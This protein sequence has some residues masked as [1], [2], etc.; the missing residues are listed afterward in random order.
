[1][2]SL[3]TVL[4]DFDIKPF[5]HILPSLEKASIATADLLTLDAV[6]VAR[7]A[8]VPPGEVKKLAT[9]LINGLHGCLDGESSGPGSEQSS[10]VSRQHGHDL[11]KRWKTISTLDDDFDDILGGGIAAEHVTEFVGERYALVLTDGMK[12]C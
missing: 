3:L 9:A 8:Q 7:R 11:I 4:P 1:M 6:D 5:T 10:F 12:L 2:T